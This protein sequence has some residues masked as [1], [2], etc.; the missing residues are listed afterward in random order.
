MSHPRLQLEQFREFG[1]TLEAQYRA[2]GHNNPH[3]LSFI[4]LSQAIIAQSGNESSYDMAEVLEGVL[5][6]LIESVDHTYWAR[7]STNSEAVRLVYEKLQLKRLNLPPEQRLIC[8]HQLVRYIEEKCSEEMLRGIGIY[9]GNDNL[10]FV[11]NWHNKAALLK[12]LNAVL[13]RVYKHDICKNVVINGLPNLASLQQRTAIVFEKYKQDRTSRWLGYSNNRLA[14]ELLNNLLNDICLTKYKKLQEEGNQ[15]AIRNDYHTR[16]GSMLLLIMDLENETL[17]LN[18]NGGWFNHGSDLLKKLK[19]I[20]NPAQV[21][22]NDKI[23]ALEAVKKEIDDFRQLPEI[24]T[25]AIR[26]RWKSE[27]VDLFQTLTAFSE[28]V[29]EFD[30]KVRAERAK[31]S[32]ANRS[33]SFAVGC[34]TQTALTAATPY[35]TV[36]IGGG[37]ASAVGGPIGFALY[38]LTITGIKQLMNTQFITTLEA[39]LYGWLF[40]SIGKVASKGASGVVK[41]VFDS[42]DRNNLRILEELLPYDERVL[43]V[44]YVNTLLHLPMVSDEEKAKLRVRRGLQPGEFLPLPTRR[45]ENPAVRL[46]QEPPAAA[47]VTQADYAVTQR[48]PVVRW[49]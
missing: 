29:R 45:L 3:R 42:K 26:Q 25:N 23:R 1:P 46:F 4:A 10:S 32:V 13:N 33:T 15:D 24:E 38:M 22:F 44:K 21:D 49:L 2:T 34:A 28:K 35:L 36:T 47:A 18:A 43:F 7:A 41:F 8:L 27:G 6:F 37:I 31:P 19:E 39:S 40:E 9:P 5:I 16:L 14:Q 30:A 48:E 17:F 20:L 12:D 11:S